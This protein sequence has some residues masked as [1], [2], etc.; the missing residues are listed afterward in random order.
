MKH[1]GKTPPVRGPRG[2]G[3]R[4]IIFQDGPHLPGKPTFSITAG[5]PANAKLAVSEVLEKAAKRNSCSASAAMPCAA[6][7]RRPASPRSDS[8]MPI[9]PTVVNGTIA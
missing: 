5:I 1:Q 4:S 8:S 2:V 3:T 6:A 7:A 9:T